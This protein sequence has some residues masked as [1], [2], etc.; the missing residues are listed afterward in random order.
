[1]RSKPNVIIH[2]GANQH[3]VQVR[4]SEDTFVTFDPNTMERKERS[5]FHREF[6]NAFRQTRG[7]A[8]T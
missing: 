6:M 3:R 8:A 7:V 1:M 4:T 5:A 2:M